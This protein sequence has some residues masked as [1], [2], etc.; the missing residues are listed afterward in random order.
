MKQTRE[1]AQHRRVNVHVRD[2][3]PTGTH[4]EERWR[5]R[6]KYLTEIQRQIESAKGKMK[7]PEAELVASN[8]AELLDQLKR[9]GLTKQKVATTAWPGPSPSD[10][11]SKLRYYTLPEGLKGPKREQRCKKLVRDPRKYLRIAIVLSDLTDKEHPAYY[12]STIFAGTSHETVGKV[13]Y[14]SEQYERYLPFLEF[15]QRLTAKLA[16]KHDLPRFFREVSR[17]EYPDSYETVDDE[18]NQ[19]FELGSP[20]QINPK[21]LVSRGMLACFLEP[22]GILT[23]PGLELELVP[24]IPLY[25]GQIEGPIP[26]LVQLSS[27]PARTAGDASKQRKPSRRA[28]TYRGI[29]TRYAEVHIAIVPRDD[30][31]RCKPV[32]VQ[33]PLDATVDLYERPPGAPRRQVRPRPVYVDQD[34]SILHS[35]MTTDPRRSAAVIRYWSPSDAQPSRNVLRCGKGYYRAVVRDARH[36]AQ[37]T[38]SP[39][40]ERGDD[41]LLVEEPTPEGEL[42]LEAE[43]CPFDARTVHR[44]LVEIPRRHWVRERDIQVLFDGS[45]QGEP[46]AFP[47]GTLGE[48]IEANLLD[49]P[50]EVITSLER[51]I[52]LRT[53]WLEKKTAARLEFVTWLY[54]KTLADLFPESGGKGEDGRSSEDG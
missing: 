13:D 42:W 31:G 21:G 39:A 28:K 17:Y 6:T 22:E 20:D 50:S 12:L 18:G 47:M 4:L 40:R 37:D 27:T 23:L 33:L 11:A 32:F 19:V 36:M 52:R 41:W 51:K 15:F 48:A 8:L 35:K 46:G 49:T 14:T 1:P 2:G 34:W 5:E 53:E 44:F 45:F 29:L 26:V 24:H 3:L 43:Y 16:A 10:A 30:E 9:G 54:D 38:A 25:R 7:R